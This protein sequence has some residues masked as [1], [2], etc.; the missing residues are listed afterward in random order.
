MLLQDAFHSDW[1]PWNSGVSSHLWDG[2]DECSHGANKAGENFPSI[3]VCGFSLLACEVFIRTVW[4][5]SFIVYNWHIKRQLLLSGWTT[6]R[7]RCTSSK[8]ET[9]YRNLDFS[10]FFLG[11]GEGVTVSGLAGFQLL[12]N[13][14]QY[15]THVMRK[16]FLQIYSCKRRFGKS[17]LLWLLGHWSMNFG[18]WVAVWLEAFLIL[19]YFFGAFK[20]F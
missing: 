18:D 9:A 2:T 14:E 16:E 15:T 11:R 4:K 13:E 5:S 8:N 12:G 6:W 19:F 7:S 3:P 1:A 17:S 20:E 10:H